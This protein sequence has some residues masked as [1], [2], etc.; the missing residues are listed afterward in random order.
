MNV[1]EEEGH[2]EGSSSCVV[3]GTMR[4]ANDVEP[5][6][7]THT[8]GEAMRDNSAQVASNPGTSRV[9]EESD[10][11]GEI[12][13]SEPHDLRQEIR[14]KDAERISH[15][16]SD[17][18]ERENFVGHLGYPG[19]QQTG[20]RGGSRG[21]MWHGIRGSRGFEGEEVVLT[22]EMV[23]REAQ[24]QRAMDGVGHFLGEVRRGVEMEA[25]G[26]LRH[27]PVPAFTGGHQISRQIDSVPHGG[28][29]SSSG[30]RSMRGGELPRDCPAMHR[31]P[32]S[33]PGLRRGL[34]EERC[35]H[36]AMTPGRFDGRGRDA[37]GDLAFERSRGL[38]WHRGGTGDVFNDVRGGGETSPWGARGNSPPGIR[39]GHFSMERSRM[40][41]EGVRSLLREDRGQPGSRAVPRGGVERVQR[42]S[43]PALVSAS[44]VGEK[45]RSPEGDSTDFPALKKQRGDDAA[46]S[47]LTTPPTGDVV[48]AAPAS[49]GDEATAISLGRFPVVWDG[50]VKLKS[51]EVPL[52]LRRLGGSVALVH[53]LPSDGVKVCLPR[54]GSGAVYR[55]FRE[56]MMSEL[57]QKVQTLIPNRVQIS[58]RMPLKPE[59]I[60]DFSARVQKATAGGASAMLL[61]M[62]PNPRD[63]ESGAARDAFLQNLVK[64]L[65]ERKV[66]GVVQLGEIGE[67]GNDA[68]P[69]VMYLFPPGHL[70][71][72]YLRVCSA[73]AIADALF[74]CHKPSQHFVIKLRERELLGV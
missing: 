44:E 20:R 16:G 66:A 51:S 72:A 65:S 12:K 40:G 35:G 36:E 68:H 28:R 64:Y 52:G 42:G 37:R 25:G 19:R 11:E 10:E 49:G 45:R 56:D 2:V 7:V 43:V 60:T 71:E 18:Y 14:I 21:G 17:R 67:A 22:R 73:P 5:G 48:G 26:T 61:A 13:E 59:Q 15:S 23:R 70:A 31:R 69:L 9:D 57:D 55:E 62:P 41:L 46:F 33:P 47:A 34:L 74:L 8:E 29:G 54:G 27:S 50:S 6:E 58:Q 32:P 53:A 4:T 30:V 38:E 1:D 24:Q 3:E 39:Q 63:Q